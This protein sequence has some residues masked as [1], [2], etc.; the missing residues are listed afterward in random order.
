MIDLDAI[1]RLFRSQARPEPDF[2]IET[3]TRYVPVFIVDEFPEVWIFTD[4]LEVG[5]L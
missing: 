3:P 5:D 4:E 1:K 2:Y